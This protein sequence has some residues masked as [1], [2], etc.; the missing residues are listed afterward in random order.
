MPT[1]PSRPTLTPDQARHILG[2]QANV[3]TE[4]IPDGR[5]AEYMASCPGAAP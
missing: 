4:Y 1:S 2:A 3:W 5:K